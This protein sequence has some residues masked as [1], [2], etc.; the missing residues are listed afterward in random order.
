MAEVGRVRAD[1][2]EVHTCLHEVKLKSSQPLKIYV[3][4]CQAIKENRK[5]LIEGEDKTQI[6]HY[7]LI[8]L[9]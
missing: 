1:H 4:N 8:I 7:S 6:T 5:D 2:A 9:N 3:V